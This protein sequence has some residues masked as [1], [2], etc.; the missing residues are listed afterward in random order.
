M[1]KIFLKKIIN[2]ILDVVSIIASGFIF[3]FVVTLY[4]TITKV[5]AQTKT[6]GIGLYLTIVVCLGFLI[7]FFYGIYGGIKNKY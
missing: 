2:I 5:P 7:N 6:L 1:A 3:M 4:T